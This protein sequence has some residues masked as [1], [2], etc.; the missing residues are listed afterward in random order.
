MILRSKNALFDSFYLNVAQKL[1]KSKACADTGLLDANIFQRCVTFY[2][3][4]AQFL[5]MTM[6]DKKS[7]DLALTGSRVAIP[8][9]EET[10]K[11]FSSLPEWII[12]DMADFLLFA[13]Q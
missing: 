6:L 4:V 9:K 1:C 5:L 7:G 11:I 10:P 8:L 12:D 13:M 3:S 2:S